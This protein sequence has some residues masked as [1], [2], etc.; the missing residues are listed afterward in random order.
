MNRAWL[1][2]SALAYGAR[3]AIPRHVLQNRGHQ[4][5]EGLSTVFRAGS[6]LLLSE[7]AK[8]EYRLDNRSMRKTRGA[9]SPS[10][11]IP[12]SIHPRFP[13]Y[14][15]ARR[16]TARARPEYQNTRRRSQ[17]KVQQRLRVEYSWCRYRAG[18][19]WVLVD[20]SSF[21]DETLL[22]TLRSHLC[23][24]GSDTDTRRM[25]NSKGDSK[26]VFCAG[27]A[28]N[29]PLGLLIERSAKVLRLSD[30]LASDV[31]RYL[32]WHDAIP[33]TLRHPLAL[34]LPLVLRASESNV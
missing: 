28:R 10:R 15:I 5:Q 23:V 13:H 7:R 26:S 33:V 2:I 31:F 16:R 32:A 3:C 19:P 22:S 29:I 1:G 9:S 8:P 27:Y 25:A 30:A 12:T 4:D 14:R 24:P 18:I 6:H 34:D 20:T 17:P 11:W 21:A